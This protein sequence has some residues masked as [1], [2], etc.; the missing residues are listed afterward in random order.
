[1]KKLLALG[2][3]FLMIFSLCACGNDSTDKDPVENPTD[4]SQTSSKEDTTPKF[5]VTVTDADG[6]AVAGVMVQMCNTSCV[7]AMTNADGIATFNLEITD[8]YKLSVMSCPEGYEYTGEAEIYIEEG[9]TEY[10]L[11]ITKK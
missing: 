9:S 11:E 3:T 4:S 10:S 2:L 5:E 7:P 8:G 1:M 6:N